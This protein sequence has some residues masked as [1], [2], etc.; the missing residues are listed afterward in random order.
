MIT[1]RVARNVVL[2][3]T[4]CLIATTTAQGTA[5]PGATREDSGKP[6]SVAVTEQVLS[7]ARSAVGLA[8]AGQPQVVEETAPILREDATP[9]LHADFLQRTPWVVIIPEFRLSLPSTPPGSA[10]MYARTLNVYIDPKTRQVLKVLTDWPPSEPPIAS[11]PAWEIAT[12]QLRLTQ[13]VYQEFAQG[14]PPITFLEALDIIQRDGGTP[15]IAKQITAVWVNWSKMG[16]E[17]TPMWVITLRGIPPIRP[18]RDV[19]P[20]ALNHLRY[21]VDPVK[22]KWIYATTRPQPGGSP[23]EVPYPKKGP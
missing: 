6:T 5:N 7:V 20:D 4:V 2:A 3:L 17:P 8:D 9:F 22:K 18:H 11:E 10:D 21:V 1:A 14:T 12:E 19:H 23:A 15:L 16:K 13:E